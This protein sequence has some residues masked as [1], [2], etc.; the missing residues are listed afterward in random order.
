MGDNQIEPE[1]D[2]VIDGTTHEYD[3]C[4]DGQHKKVRYTATW[5]SFGS[6]KPIFVCSY[7]L[8]DEGLEYIYSSAKPQKHNQ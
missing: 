4:K 1:G 5:D 3:V 2:L 6:G 8:I 7:G